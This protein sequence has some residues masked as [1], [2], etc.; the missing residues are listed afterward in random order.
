MFSYTSEKPE[1]IEKETLPISVKQQEETQKLSEEIEE[2]N[3]AKEI[4][5]ILQK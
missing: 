2:T 4:T 5:E 1:I 3:I